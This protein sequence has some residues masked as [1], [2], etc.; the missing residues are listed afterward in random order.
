M[1]LITSVLL[2]PFLFGPPVLFRAVTEVMGKE[3]MKFVQSHFKLHSKTLDD[4]EKC[5]IA[6]WGE[7]NPNYL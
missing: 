2:V 1:L 4:T 6:Y 3:V 7:S 5:K